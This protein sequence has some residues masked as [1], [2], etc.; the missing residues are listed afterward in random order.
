MLKHDIIVIGAS[1][2]G[3]EA[4]K[5]FVHEIPTDLPG[6]IF[7]VLHIP[8]EY[9]SALPEILSH[10]GPLPALHPANGS[11]IEHRRVYVAPPD[12]HMLIERGS[13]YLVHGPKENRH[14]PAIDPLFRSAAVAY[15]QRVVGVVL[16]GMLNDGTA[17]LLA[18]KRMG[19]VTVVQDPAEAPYPDMPYS[20]LQHVKVDYCLRL[21]AIG[22][23]VNK[24]TREPTP[25]EKQVPSVDVLQEIGVVKMETPL[26]SEHNFAGKPSAFSCPDCEGVLWEIQ[27]DAFLRFRCRVGHAFS[28]E[29]ALV[30]QG[31]QIEK[32]LWTA[33]KALEEK[34]NLSQRMAELARAKQQYRSAQYLESSAQQVEKDALA[35]RQ[36]LL[37]MHITS[38]RGEELPNQAQVV[39]NKEMRTYI[40][41]RDDL[42]PR[43]ARM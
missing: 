18:I 19:G 35:L 26:L 22:A 2:G 31:E 5:M 24:L 33:L 37:Q 6:A 9:P 41:C 43:D 34:G 21:E 27:D 16:T 3:V 39:E 42:S 8:A 20:A 11:P 17:G 7:V 29:N 13:V 32:A 25:P 15:G 1:A 12:C 36:L 10:A 30:M 28:A 38:D 4:L 14:R 40:S 23:L